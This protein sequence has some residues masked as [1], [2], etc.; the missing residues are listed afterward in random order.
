[1][2]ASGFDNEVEFRLEDQARAQHEDR[3]FRRRSA[4]ECQRQ[5]RQEKKAK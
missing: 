5:E 3:I 1:M 2:G 4:E